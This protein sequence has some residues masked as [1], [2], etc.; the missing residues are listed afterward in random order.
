MPSATSVAP[1]R[2]ANSLPGRTE[3]ALALVVV[4]P[5]AGSTPRLAWP[6]PDPFNAFGC[7]GLHKM[8]LCGP[9]SSAD[10]D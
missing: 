1:S 8:E 10:K 5:V 3:G 7:L 2:P 4:D 9:T 6:G